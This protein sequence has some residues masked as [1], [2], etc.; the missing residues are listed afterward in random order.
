MSK[1]IAAPM[2]LT[3]MALTVMHDVASG[4]YNIDHIKL[5]HGPANLDYEDLEEGDFSPAALRRKVAR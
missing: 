1:K 2:A 5:D 3:V 4:R